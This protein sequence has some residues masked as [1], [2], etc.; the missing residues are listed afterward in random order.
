M[1]NITGDTRLYAILADPIHHVKTPQSMNRLFKE[2]GVNAVL[3]PMHVDAQHLHFAVAGLRAMRNLDG[4]VVT[5]PHKSAIVDLCDELTPAASRVG[6]VNVVRRDL[7]GRLHGDILDGRGF[8]AGL[9]TK[10][11]DPAGM[12]VYLAGAG[13]AANAIAFALAEAGIRQ[14]TIANRTSAKAMALIDRVAASYPDLALMAG[15]EDPSGHDLVVN[16]TSL[17]LRP[18]DPVPCD[19][20]RLDPA[21]IVAEIIMHPAETPLLKAAKAKGC[22]IHFGAPMLACQ[23]EMMVAFMSGADTQRIGE[24]NK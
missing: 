19:V 2:R 5:V 21:Q 10:G 17:G 8:V 6:A 4:F 16:G 22:R 15:T 23:I 20:A 7:D 13:G 3:V 11:I 18:E 9:R 14:L 12:S 24:A 1:T